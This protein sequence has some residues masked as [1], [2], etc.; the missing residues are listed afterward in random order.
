MKRLVALALILAGPAFA[1]V[2]LNQ[3]AHINDSLRA[4]RIGDVIR[5]TC[6][7]I[8]ARMIVVYTKAKELERYALDQGYTEEAVEAFLE[9]K[10]ERARLKAE[11]AAYLKAAGAVAGD[12]E[13]YCKVGRD[14]I[15]KG[16]LIG[17]LLRSSE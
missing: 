8:S 16:S 1:Q 12:P 6:P 15:A 11:A 17:Q 7:T 9:D 14:E 5:K 13:S 2:P 10:T 3:E 4:A